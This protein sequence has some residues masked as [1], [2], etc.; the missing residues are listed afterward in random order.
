MLLLAFLGF[1]ALGVWQWQRLAWKRDLIARVEA[2]VHAAP[3]PPPARHDWP[4]IDAADFEY[5]RL[6]IEGH[7]LPGLDTRVQAVTE[8][9]AGFWWLTPLRLADGS[10]VLVNRGFA[11]PDW[12]PPAAPAAAEPISLI[13]LLR[14]SE[15]GG[16]FLRRN[17]PAQERWYSRDV[18]AIAAAR[19]LGP[20]APYFVDA[21]RA[22][23][24][25]GADAAAAA[26]A[27]AAPRWPLAGLTVVRFRDNHLSYALTWFALALM[28][29]WAGAWLAREARRPFRSRSR[30]PPRPPSDAG[31]AAL[32]HD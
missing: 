19:G 20:V 21:Q 30:Y 14:M 27:S 29:A 18:A 31:H 8:A 2:R 28:T 5:R 11:P 15:P 13:G 24:P 23:A 7:Y 6:R 3:T 17:V 12:R 26:A 1:T 22:D 9:G 25:T 10:V 4:H 16:G 32:P